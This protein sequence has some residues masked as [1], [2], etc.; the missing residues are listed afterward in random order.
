[1][2]HTYWRQ[3]LLPSWNTHHER[4]LRPLQNGGGLQILLAY[5]GRTTFGGTKPEDLEGTATEMMTLKLELRRQD[6]SFTRVSV[7]SDSSIGKCSS[8][9][10]KT[11]GRPLG[12]WTR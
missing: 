8:K 1:M 3:C 5:D 4:G 12:I 2:P 7:F 6:A 9:N 10:P 11:F